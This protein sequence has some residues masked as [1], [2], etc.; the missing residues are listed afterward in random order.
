MPEIDFAFLADAAETVPG[1]ATGAAVGER[2]ADTEVID[3]H[4]ARDMDLFGPPSWHAVHIGQGHIPEA[5]DP[6]AGYREAAPGEW[7]GKLRAAMAYEAGKQPTHQQ[8]IDQHC[9]APAV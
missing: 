1:L 4:I 2:V 8:F 5:C 7:L 9:K 3:V 6:V